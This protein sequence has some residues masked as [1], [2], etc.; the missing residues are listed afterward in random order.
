MKSGQTLL[1]SEIGK[2]AT[3]TGRANW[4]NRAAG[5]VPPAK[6]TPYEMRTGSHLSSNPVSNSKKSQ[7]GNSKM[8]DGDW[9]PKCAENGPLLQFSGS[10]QTGGSVLTTTTFA[11]LLA[12]LKR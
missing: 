9:A 11:L 8:R 4:R 2:C 5:T 6:L 3:E 7:V 10:R 1:K 12:K